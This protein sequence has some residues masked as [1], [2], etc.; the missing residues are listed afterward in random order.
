MIIQAVHG[1]A[2]PQACFVYDYS[3]LDILRT[4]TSTIAMQ[5]VIDVTGDGPHHAIYCLCGVDEG[6]VRT[7]RILQTSTVL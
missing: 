4:I 2:A 1:T 5:G 3:N 6:V 7:A